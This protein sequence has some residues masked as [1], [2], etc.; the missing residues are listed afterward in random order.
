MNHRDLAAFRIY[1]RRGGR[2]VA[3]AW[4]WRGGRRWME[5]RGERGKEE[6]G[7][8][9]EGDDQKDSKD[10]YRGEAHASIASQESF[11]LLVIQV[12]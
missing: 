10:W 11:E 7:R 4:V 3:T 1:Y 12:T 6:E 8:R 9:Q 5:R 2:E